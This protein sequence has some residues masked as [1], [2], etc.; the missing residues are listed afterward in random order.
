MQ[1]VDG[2]QWWMLTFG[3]SEIHLVLSDRQAIVLSTRPRRLACFNLFISLLIF[4]FL[5]RMSL[6]SRLYKGVNQK[7]EI[8][9]DFPTK[10]EECFQ[11]RIQVRHSDT[12]TLYHSNQASYFTYFM[13]AAVEGTKLG[14]F[15][16]LK[17]DLLSY[18]IE[19]ME[20]LYRGE[21]HPGDELLVYVWED[22]MNGLRLLGQI[23]KNGKSIW[24]GRLRF[25]L[26]INSK[27]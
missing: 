6:F 8:L 18:P 25:R 11:H 2:M 10:P 23:E 15:Q 1:A 26:D 7:V 14:H 9:N 17:G 20:C 19:W 3:S 24:I 21:S 22:P 13:D 5:F 4:L 16:L 27:I 12:D